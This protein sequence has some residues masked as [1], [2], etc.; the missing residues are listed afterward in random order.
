L[1]GEP[2]DAMVQGL[3]EVRGRLGE[4]GAAHRAAETVLELLP[5]RAVT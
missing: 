1:P 3:A 2:R 5:P 4:V